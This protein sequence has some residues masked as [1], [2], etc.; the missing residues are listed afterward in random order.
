M[1]AETP[2]SNVR[3]FPTVEAEGRSGIV[4]E[5]LQVAEGGYLGPAAE[6]AQASAVAVAEAAGPE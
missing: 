1:M 2:V 3:P 4:V 5:A 6:E